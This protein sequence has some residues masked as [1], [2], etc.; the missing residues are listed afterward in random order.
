MLSGNAAVYLGKRTNELGAFPIC[1]FIEF[2]FSDFKKYVGA[3]FIS[4]SCYPFF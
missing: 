4:F 3:L 1:I 2:G